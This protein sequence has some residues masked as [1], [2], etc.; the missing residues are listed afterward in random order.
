MEFP[1][2]PIFLDYLRN[3]PFADVEAG[4]TTPHLDLLPLR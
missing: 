1:S 3:T 2:R 4:L